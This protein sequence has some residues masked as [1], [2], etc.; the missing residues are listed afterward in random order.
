MWRFCV[1]YIPLNQVTRIIAYP[2]PR[3]DTAV[4]TACGQSA[5]FWIFNP[6][7]GYHQLAVAE[8]SQEKLAFQGADAIKWTYMV[9]PF[10]PV[11]GPATFIAF[12]HDVSSAWKS[13]AQ[14]HGL[15][16][17]DDNNSTNIVNDI[18]SWC[19]DLTNSLLLIVAKSIRL[20]LSLKKSHIFPKR[21]K[22]VGID[23]CPDGN[24]PAM[25]KFELISLWP[26]PAT[27][28]DVARLV[29]FGQFYSSL[30]QT[31]KS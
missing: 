18:F 23:I 31:L 22:F 21:I 25:S 27:V 19:S 29:G 13:L 28:R 26:A 9:M 4:M 3:C 16:I 20:S 15:T 17:D 12:I 1:N 14:S 5:W 10:G 30:S 11:N 6:P 7:M 24:R 8:S 2:I